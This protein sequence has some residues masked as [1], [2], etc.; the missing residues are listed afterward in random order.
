MKLSI[1]GTGYVGL[2]TGACLAEVSHD[3]VCIDI[4]R[5]TVDPVSNT[6]LRATRKAELSYAV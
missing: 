2:V 3:V 4:D 1:F 5:D 6:H